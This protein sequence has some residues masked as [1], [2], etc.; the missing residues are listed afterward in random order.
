M[1]SADVVVPQAKCFTKGQLECFAGR[2]AEGDQLWWVVDR[3][4]QRDRGT[5]S[6]G[7]GLLRGQQLGGQRVRVAQQTQ[8]Q[9]VGGDLAIVGLVRGVLRGDDDVA[10]PGGEAFESLVGV[11]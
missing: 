4:W 3:R 10:G 1:L 6:F 5:N 9:V 7:I 8:Q 2:A 11:E